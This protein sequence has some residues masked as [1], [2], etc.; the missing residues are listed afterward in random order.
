M[1][2]LYL[3]S[4]IIARI[5]YR[6]KD[7]FL[8]Q[9]ILPFSFVSTENSHLYSQSKES[10]LPDSRIRTRL[11][12]RTSLVFT[13]CC[14]RETYNTKTA[15]TG[16]ES[17]PMGRRSFCISITQKLFLVR[18][19]RCIFIH[20]RHILHLKSLHA[21]ADLSV[22]FVEVNNLSLDLLADG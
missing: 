18:I 5:F 1:S 17:D 14:T 8:P 3:K 9:I 10:A 7:Y 21:Q 19:N 6:F 20:L 12:S 11:L 2:L 22:V 16:S 13:Q 4:T 15:R